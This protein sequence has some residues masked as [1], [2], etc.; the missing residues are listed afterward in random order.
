M[1]SCVWEPGKPKGSNST[2]A[3][4]PMEAVSVC[5]ATLHKE[6]EYAK[7]PPYAALL[8]IS[9]HAEPEPQAAC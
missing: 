7:P 5:P 2:R 6:Q 4:S 9:P 3:L 1:S 8:A